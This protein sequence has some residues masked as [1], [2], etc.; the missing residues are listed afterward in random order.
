[1]KT[2]F[3]PPTEQISSK[4]NGNGD[5]ASTTNFGN[6]KRILF[7]N[8]VAV[9]IAASLSL[10]MISGTVCFAES[11]VSV[12]TPRPNA[13]PADHIEAPTVPAPRT[14]G[15]AINRHKAILER[16]TKGEIDLC[17]IGDSITEFWNDNDIWQMYYGH[18]KAANFGVGGDRTGN[19]LWRL[20][21]GDLD[22]RVQPKV[23]IVLIGINNMRLHDPEDIAK[24]ITAIVTLLREKRPQAKVLLLGIFPRDFKPTPIRENVSR[25][26]QLISK[27]DDGGM[28]RFLNFGDKFLNADGTISPDVFRD[29]VHLAPVGYKVW[30]E[31][32]NP[33]LLELLQ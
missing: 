17:F 30:A 4:I 24:G 8:S 10:W 21:N 32:M 20:Q 12:S 11:S 31:N 25:V 28:V 14:G 9:S 23:F 29:N 15:T 1:M 16:A 22:E 7:T 3:L 33:L 6:G 19:V 2:P 27:L 18:L 26:N 5:H 13:K